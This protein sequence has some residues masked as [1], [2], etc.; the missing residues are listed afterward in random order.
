MDDG[1]TGAPAMAV[2]GGDG[3]LLH[4]SPTFCRLL[5]L[6]RRDPAG[7][8]WTDL[9]E[10]S[11]RIP[12]V[13]AFSE[14][15]GSEPGTGVSVEWRIAGRS[16]ERWLESV[17]VAGPR[18]EDRPTP[19]KPV[20]CGDCLI[21]TS[22][23]VTARRN[24]DEQIR[25]ERARLQKLIDQSSDLVTIVEADGGFR[26]ASRDHV[27]GYDGTYIP[28]DIFD[29]VHPDDRE[30]LQRLFVQ[31]LT[32]QDPTSLTRLYEYRARAADGTWRW[33]ETSA[34]NLL[35]D[36]D[37]HAIVLHSRD[38]SARRQA[39]EELQQ[40]TSRLRTLVAH[41]NVG[42]AMVDRD[43]RYVVV[44]RAVADYLG[45]SDPDNL[46]GTF[47]DELAPSLRPRV[48]KLVDDVDAHM[49]R[50][51]AV[52]TARE[53]VVDERVRI[54]D[55]IIGRTFIPITVE[56]GPA[57]HLWLYRDM[58]GE[59][60]AEAERERLLDQEVRQNQR[61]REL[62]AAKSELVAA[63]SHEL[64]TP[65]TSV[66][67][68]VDL[69]Q[70]GLGSDA[71]DDQ[72]EYL[73]V[74]ARNARR[75]LRSV[76]DLLTIDRIESEPMTFSSVPVQLPD[77]VEMAVASIVPAAEQK[78]VEVRSS[79]VS[80]PLVRGDPDRLG[81]MVDNLLTNAV[82]FTP[83]GGE[84]VVSLRTAD[85]RWELRVVDTGI[86]IPEAEQE[87]LFRTFFRGSNARREGIHGSGLGMSIVRSVVNLHH[88][89][90]H[91]DSAEGRGTTVTVRLPFDPGQAEP[92]GS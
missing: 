55:R 33:L 82:K 83:P 37:V 42:V 53:L 84:V 13:A 8:P 28:E 26:W 20:P 85:G 49:A 86:G 57:G 71:V 90:I 60:A 72:R 48:A 1:R 52:R 63:I 67:S 64:R 18:S 25:R 34:A 66:I 70:E 14:V 11:D 68:F 61:L 76:D 40:A 87:N 78:G 46:L 4:V 41:L 44:N 75:I 50:R 17:V 3:R 73:E 77:L 58:T 36:P 30:R 23:D 54:G 32:T 79:T 51:R 47:D 74:V 31:A 91:V 10:E 21:V 80:G 88:G 5:E 59:L 6:K 2:V 29:V 35:D 38:I 69:L 56:G 7:T 89:E 65:L 24:A 9:V 15:L 22:R 12:V 27:L 43:G 62:D 16:P 19:G 39:V 45:M 92:D 81:Q